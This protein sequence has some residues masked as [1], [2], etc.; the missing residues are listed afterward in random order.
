MSSPNF[1]VLCTFV[2]WCLGFMPACGMNSDVW[3]GFTTSGTGC[4][5]FVCMI[6][7]VEIRPEKNWRTSAGLLLGDAPIVLTW[8]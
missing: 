2:C 8:C 5:I 4:C 3:D 6:E 7:D 1:V